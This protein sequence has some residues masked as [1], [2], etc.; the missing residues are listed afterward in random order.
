MHLT[1]PNNFIIKK[2]TAD[3]GNCCKSPF[4]NSVQKLNSFSF[5]PWIAWGE[6]LR[7]GAPTPTAKD[8]GA[9]WPLCYCTELVP[10]SPSN[11]S[12]FS[13]GAAIGNGR[14]ETEIDK[15]EQRQRADRPVRFNNNN[16]SNK[17]GSKRL[18]RAVCAAN[19]KGDWIFIKSLF[20]CFPFSIAR[21]YCPPDRFSTRSYTH[22]CPRISIQV[23][24]SCKEG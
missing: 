14:I 7:K 10:D 3:L 17:V 12:S 6:K 5:N 16:H 9:C 19:K 24:G 22:Y 1:K 4:F 23:K 13:P 21:F 15:A 2:K 20:I 8:I 18:G 11:A